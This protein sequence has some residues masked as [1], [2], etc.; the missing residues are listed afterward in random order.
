MEG[1]RTRMYCELSDDVAIVHQECVHVNDARLDC[2]FRSAV[3]L[4][5]ILMLA[6]WPSGHSSVI[7]MSLSSDA[8]HRTRCMLMDH[9]RSFALSCSCSG[10]C[11][12]IVALSCSCSAACMRIAAESCS[13]SVACMRTSAMSCS[14]SAALHSLACCACMLLDAV[15]VNRWRGHARKLWERFGIGHLTR[16]V[17]ILSELGVGMCLRVF[18]RENHYCLRARHC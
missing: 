7:S 14:C 1:S 12:R 15:H 5:G 18:T 10:A 9:C 13:C 2:Y 16:G 4:V 17:D 8:L 3:L 11:M 6:D